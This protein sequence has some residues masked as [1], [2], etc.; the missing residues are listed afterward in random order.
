MRP[1]LLSTFALLL[2]APVLLG[3]GDIKAT[4]KVF[5]DGTRSNTVVDPDQRTAI[6]TIVD[7]AD[8]VLRKITFLLD[9]HNIAIG[10]V[11]YDPKGNIR[12]KESF[13][14]DGFNRVLETTFSSGEG[15]L[16]GKRLYV[17]NGDKVARMDDYDAGGALIAPAARPAGPGR[18]DKKKR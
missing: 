8:R 3:Q 18:P 12:Y 7:T 11:H 14:R 6:E 4:T 10:A 16:L 1:L 15:K 17:Y 2:A 5:A 9:E 13:Q